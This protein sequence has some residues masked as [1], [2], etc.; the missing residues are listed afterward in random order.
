[1]GSSGINESTWVTTAMI[2]MDVDTKT[3]VTT[4]TDTDPRTT[5]TTTMDM[6]PGTT[7]DPRTA[8]TTTVDPRTTMTI[9]TTKEVTPKQM[10]LNSSP[11]P[12]RRKL[13]SIFNLLFLCHFS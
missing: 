11:Y 2:T 7:M 5:M 10:F 8:T 3:T 12:G 1:M 6:G 9:T 13:Q 4:T